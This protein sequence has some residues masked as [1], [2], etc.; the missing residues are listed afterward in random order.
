MGTSGA[1]VTAGPLSGVRVVSVEQY[2]AGPYCTGILAALGADVLKIENPASG[3]D[4]R[5]GYTPIV[6]GVSSGFAAYNRG[7]QSVLLDIADPDDSQRFRSL[8][9]EADVFVS[10]LRPGALGRR[11]LDVT[12]LRDERPD[13]II[14]EITGFGTTGGEFGDWPAFDSVIQ[15]MSGLSSLL[16][17]DAQ[18]RPALGPMGTSDIQTGV[19]AALGIVAA[20][21]GR[22][23]GGGGAHIDAAMYDIAV[24]S[25][26]RPLTLMEFGLQ[27]NEAG[28]DAQ[29]AV[30]TFRALGGWVAVV[31]PTDEMWRRCC[32]AMSR[33]DLLS[34]AGLA[35]I[36]ARAERMQSVIIPALE[37][38]A[39]TERLDPAQCAERLRDAGLPAGIV[40]S[41]ADV[42]NSPQ[43]A[44]RS[45][46]EPLLGMSPGSPQI[47]IPRFPLLFDHAPLPSGPV[48]PL[49]DD[50]R[51]G[52]S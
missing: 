30:G 3:G 43:L 4:P 15:A 9:A 16:A 31:I 45:M 50:V 6:G 26:E 1:D 12:G 46:F 13:L 37:G 34:E 7:K 35:G 8:L 17:P 29:S 41:L 47:S 40:Q 10:N 20:L 27:P 49:G 21:A 39:A 36:E 14:C 48:P 11:G 52:E 23:R 33:E 44:H 5:R 22:A 24:A 51:E 32:S 28:R 38:W 42:R 18:G 25:L 2:I 19:W